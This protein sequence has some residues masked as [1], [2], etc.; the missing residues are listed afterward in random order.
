MVQSSSATPEEKALLISHINNGLSGYN[1]TPE[2]ERQLKISAIGAEIK[3][4][5]AFQKT[6]KAIDATSGGKAKD[7][8][9]KMQEA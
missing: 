1:I 4:S 7:E 8:K 2:A 6:E 5:P 9:K 3:A